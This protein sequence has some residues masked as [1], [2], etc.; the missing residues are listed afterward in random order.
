MAAISISSSGMDN[1]LDMDGMY[2]EPLA[3]E[4]SVDSS[5]CGAYQRG[6]P[7]GKVDHATKL[8]V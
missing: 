8:I 2:D 3:V 7:V 5:F 6:L 4:K 1:R